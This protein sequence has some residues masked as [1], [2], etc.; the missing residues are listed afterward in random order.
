LVILDEIFPAI[1][2]DLLSE[3]DLLN[4]IFSKPIEIE[5]ILTGR[6]ASP[7]FF[8]IADLV[9]DMV[10]VKHYLRKGISSRE[11]FDH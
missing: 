5:L 4:F 3:E 8:E 2:W 6:Y 1:H 10:E 9:T 11:G 7:K